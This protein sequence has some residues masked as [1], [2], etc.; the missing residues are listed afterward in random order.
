M[1]YLIIFL[2]L[3][4]SLTV[5]AWANNLPDQDKDGIPDQDE[6]NIYHTDPSNPDTDGDGYQDSEELKNGYSPLNSKLIKLEEVDTD[7]DGLSDRMELNFRT[8]LTNPDTDKD[9][10]KDGEEIKNGY[11]PL[12]GNRAKL[13]KKIEVNLAKQKLSYFL[14]DVRL[15]IFPVSSGLYGSTPKGNFTISNKSLKAWSPYGLWMPYWLGIT[16]KQFGIHELPVWPNGYREGQ[17]HL[18]KPASH[19]CIRLGIGPA[20]ELYNWAEVGTLVKIY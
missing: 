5:P 11:N 20:K 1:K 4:L 14:G 12:L 7:N 8:D 9:G 17:D 10:F 19:G 2:V 15:G 18:G 6:I 3:F 16:G 13:E